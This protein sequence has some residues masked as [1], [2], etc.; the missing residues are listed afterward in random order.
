MEELLVKAKKVS[1]AA[2][3]FGV[4]AEETEVQFEANRLK[5][6]R[7]K[8][9]NL[10]ALRIIKDGRIGYSVATDEKDIQRLIEDAVETARFGTEAVFAFPGP[11]E[12]PAVDIF[13]ARVSGVLTED[14]ISLGQGMID[15][16]KGHSPE[17]LCEAG[18]G[19][20][21]VTTRIMNSSGFDASFRQSFFS[22]AI[23][24]TLIRG[25]DMLF[26]GDGD[27]SCH[28]ITDTGKIIK[29]VK[30]QLDWAKETAPV[31]SGML[32][33][34]FTPS[35]V[36]SGL[37]GPLMS[38]L[39]GKTVLE[40]ASPLKDRLGEQVFDKKFN[41]ADDALQPYR[42]GS[43]PFDDEGVPCGRNR[44]IENGVPQAFF[45]D[46]QTAALAK[47]KSTGNGHRGGGLPN[48]SPNAFVIAA[49]ETSFDDIVADIKEGI[50]IEQLMGAG[51]GN[52]LGG[53]F[54]GNVLLGYRVEN[55]KITGRIKNAMVY[56]NI[57]KLLKDI[58]A[59]GSDGKW[60]GGSLFTP[61]L[62]LPGI[63]VASK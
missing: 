5:H 60:L 46:L 11:S 45:Y 16:I 59:V 63:S 19:R 36:A 4:T 21:V 9:S 17:I 42:P 57:Y 62:Y 31:P 39:N 33:V 3:V 12:Y 56:G 51:Q 50:L 6:V 18:V 7:S 32:P 48:P 29:E 61:S 38:A 53:D 13:D 47:K 54:S 34:I 37:I 8:Q 2:E 10:V 25:T 20:D 15:A 30:Q 40:G 58:A 52:I 41:L 23:E 1:Q 49:G 55:G 27:A 22:L 14:M 28:P 43:R 24:G 35:G 26:V 44:L